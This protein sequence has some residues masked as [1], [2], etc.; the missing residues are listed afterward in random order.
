MKPKEWE[1][2]P[3]VHSCKIHFAP[4]IKTM[5]EVIV[6]WYLQGN[7]SFQGFLVVQDLVHPQFGGVF[8]SGE[9]QNGGGP[10]MHG[11]YPLDFPFIKPAPSMV[12]SKKH[13]LLMVDVWV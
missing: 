2:E 8:N 12:P 9:W 7:H 1:V 6:C 4:R 10:I 11:G 13:T 3:T 5:V